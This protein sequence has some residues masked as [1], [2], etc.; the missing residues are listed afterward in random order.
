MYQLSST[1]AIDLDVAGRLDDQF[2]TE[3]PS[4][5][6]RARIRTLLVDADGSGAPHGPLVDQVAPL[7]GP[8]LSLFADLDNRNLEMQVAVDAVAVRHHI[9][10]ALLRLLHAVLHLDSHTDHSVWVALSDSPARMRTILEENHAALS[11]GSESPEALL[12]RLLLPDDVPSPGNS[13]DPADSLEAS[14]SIHIGW[15]N[16]AIGLMVQRE[17]DINAVYNK[18]KHGL[19][20]RVQDDL[21]LSFTTTPPA[22]DGTIGADVLNGP[23]TATLMDGVTVEFMARR[24]GLG[25]G[26]TGLELTQ[27]RTNPA[28]TIAEASALML[29]HALLFHAAARRHFASRPI[30]VGREIPSFPGRFVGGPLPGQLRVNRP[31]ALKY[32]LSRPLPEGAPERPL[33]LWADGSRQEMTFGGPLSVQVV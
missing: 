22:A 21:L 30:P 3:D 12:G 4:A 32:P 27:M 16:F 11:Q 20:A 26:R 5:Y 8:A 19:A 10:E 18:V 28:A 25:K 15:V 29:T 14:R 17:P 31:V 2:F 13:Q 6:F 33:L 1:E 23:T 9:G 7:L 24:K